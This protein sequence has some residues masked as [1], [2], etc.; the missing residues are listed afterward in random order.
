MSN[1]EKLKTKLDDD[2]VK[3]GK[4]RKRQEITQ[5][6]KECVLEMLHSTWQTV[7]SLWTYLSS[8][9][10]RRDK[11]QKAKEDEQAA[12]LRKVE[13]DTNAV[14]T[15]EK[16]RYIGMDCEM[17]SRVFMLTL[18]SSSSQSCVVHAG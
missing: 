11:A 5:A 2:T 8:C 3:K 12:K 18:W 6:V 10:Y 14:P 16:E 9:C 13:K 1:W 4:K 15:E 17:V 7:W